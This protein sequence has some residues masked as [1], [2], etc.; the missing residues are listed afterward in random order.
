MIVHW[1]AGID[2]RGEVR[3]QYVHAIDVAP[4]LLDLLGHRRP[5]R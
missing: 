5:L 2:A 3:D 4:T 1:P